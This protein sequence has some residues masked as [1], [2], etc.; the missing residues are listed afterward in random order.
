MQEGGPFA[1][2]R[3]SRDEAASTLVRALVTIATCMCTFD[4]AS[5]SPPSTTSPYK[6]PH[7]FSS[8]H[9]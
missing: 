6:S 5:P 8:A 4:D 2:Q 3:E 7:S 9:V 1:A